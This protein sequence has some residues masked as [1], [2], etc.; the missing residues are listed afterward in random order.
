MIA[1]SSYVRTVHINSLC[2]RNAAYFN[3]KPDDIYCNHWTLK[4]L[5]LLNRVLVSFWHNNPQWARASSFT[6]FLDHTQRRSTVG[7]TPLDE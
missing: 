3:V 4:A 5:M 6:K 7:R 1:V 2:G